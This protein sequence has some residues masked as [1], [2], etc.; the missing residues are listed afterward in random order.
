MILAAGCTASKPPSPVTPVEVIR[1]QIPASLL[2]CP[3]HPAFAG[4]TKAD[5][6]LWATDVTLAG[7]RCR[8][9][10]AAVR[11]LDEKWRLKLP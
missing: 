11:A 7:K 6:L 2:Y 4:E 3:E 1:V 8:D 5:L 9:A 10:L